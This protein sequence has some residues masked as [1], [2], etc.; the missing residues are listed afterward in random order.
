[1]AE[2]RV[3]GEVADVAANRKLVGSLGGGTGPDLS[4]RGD[5]QRTKTRPIFEHVV[6][7]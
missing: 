1:M 2:G 7:A 4:Q 3:D 6:E 5:A